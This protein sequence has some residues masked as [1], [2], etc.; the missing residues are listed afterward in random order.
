MRFGID[1]FLLHFRNFGP[2]EGD[3][4]GRGRIFP[5]FLYF[6]Q[7]CPKELPYERI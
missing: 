5:H 3:V 2:L 4:Y 7:K 1:V 6:M